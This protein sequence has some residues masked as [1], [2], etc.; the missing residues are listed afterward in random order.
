MS[1]RDKKQRTKKMKMSTK[2]IKMIKLMNT[3]KMKKNWRNFSVKVYD[4]NGTFPLF[5]LE[6]I[7]FE[8]VRL[9]FTSVFA[10]SENLSLQQTKVN[11]C[12]FSNQKYNLRICWQHHSFLFLIFAWI[13]KFF[14]E[15]HWNLL[16][17]TVSCFFPLLC[18]LQTEN[19]NKKE[20]GRF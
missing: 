19:V 15:F 7:F 10:A 16:V 1:K 9:R 20:R 18:R 6:N 12:S 4:W 3:K 11:W 5:S 8:N 2:E 13:L 17:Y 14:C